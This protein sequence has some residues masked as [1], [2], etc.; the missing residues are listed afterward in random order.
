M[1]YRSSAKPWPQSLPSLRATWR[2]LEQAG[3]SAT[4]ARLREWQSKLVKKL[5]LGSIAAALSL[6]LLAGCVSAY[7]K[8]TIPN[9]SD[10]FLIC[11]AD[12]IEQSKYTQCVEE[13][14][15]DWE[16]LTSPDQL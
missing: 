15:K 3:S 9:Y 11:V 6:S 2:R 1:S 12:S 5:K 16:V 14:L 10:E 13:A 7:Q 8:R 4:E